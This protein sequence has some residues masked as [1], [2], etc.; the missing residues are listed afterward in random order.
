MRFE[1]QGESGNVED[2]RGR[3]GGAPG[4]GNPLG[5]M[6]LP[7]GRGGLGI[8]GLLLLLVVGW[9]AGINPLDLLGGG[10]GGSLGQQPT[11]ASESEAPLRTTPAE[12]AAKTFVGKVLATTEACWHDVFEQRLG[13]PYEEPT[14]VLFRDGVRSA[15]GEA[16]SSIGPFYCPG[17]SRIYIDLSFFDEMSRTLG[18]DGDFAQ[19]YVIAHEVGHHVQNLLGTSRKVQALHARASEAEYNRASVHLELQADYFAGVWAHYVKNRMQ[20]RAELEIGDYEEAIKAAHAIGDD[21]LQR[22]ATGRVVPEKFTH[23]TAAQRTKWFKLGFES[24]D[25]LARDPFVEE[26]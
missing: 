12:E 13:R 16:A 2:Q 23:G 4:G 19:A 21:T 5:G 17:D 6:R 18:A 10:S 1:N 3:S 9:F 24:G 14:L 22:R 15:C 20:G 11:Y 7:M 25:P 26:K 8:G